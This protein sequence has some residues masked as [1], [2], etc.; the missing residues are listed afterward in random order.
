MTKVEKKFVVQADSKISDIY[1]KL[2][3]VQK[4]PFH[5]LIKTETEFWIEMK[6]KLLIIQ[7]LVIKEIPLIAGYS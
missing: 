6:Q 2:N 5:Y 7:Y 1:S 4:K 3:S